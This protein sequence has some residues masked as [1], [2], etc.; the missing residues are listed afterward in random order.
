[1]VI[2][3]KLKHT[4]L[5][6]RRLLLLAGLVLFC[7]SSPAQSKKIK[8]ANA[9]YDAKDYVKAIDA[10]KAILEDNQFAPGVKSKIA[11]CYRF[12]KSYNLA[13]RYYG[14]V[15]NGPERQSSDMYNYA[16]CLR[17]TGSIAGAKKWY[18]EYLRA[19]PGDKNATLRSTSCTLYL[20][21]A[22]S[23]KC[24]PDNF[25]FSAPDIGKMNA[26]IPFD[27]S[28]IQI[29]GEKATDYFCPHFLPGV[30][31]EARFWP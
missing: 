27:A 14:E 30:N 20:D 16:E 1:M 23:M 22:A 31:C 17:T 2:I 12:T 9:L 10:Y 8:A 18:T 15:V 28:K 7:F 13:Q 19:V 21:S 6:A 24:T 5:F 29:P 11:D 3:T 4:S 25:P 26:A